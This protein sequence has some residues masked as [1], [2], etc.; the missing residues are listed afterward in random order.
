MKERPISVTTGLPSQSG[1]RLKALDGL[2]WKQ[3]NRDAVNARRRALYVAGSDVARARSSAYRKANP[4]KVLA[5]NAT[6][7]RRFYGALRREMV[8]AYG[9]C[10]ACC[11]ESE[12][13]FLDLDHVN[14]DGKSDRAKRGN[15]QRLLVWLKANGWPRN[16]YQ[17]LCC[18]CN[19]GKAR[20]GGT[21]PH[22]QRGCHVGA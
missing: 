10:C 16:G 7:R 12:F 22:Q 18:N 14:N 15:G 20:N 17:V 6:W 8:A 3:R 5:Y 1:S 13:I 2:T 19:Q 9:G 4:A 11:G 21:C